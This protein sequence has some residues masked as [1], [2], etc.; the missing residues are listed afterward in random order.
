MR[1]VSTERAAYRVT[2]S[3][4]QEDIGLQQQLQ[5]QPEHLTLQH[6]V[7]LCLQQQQQRHHLQQLQHEQQQEMQH[8]LQQ[9]QQQQEHQHNINVHLQL[10]NSHG[11]HHQQHMSQL[12]HQQLQQQIQQQHLIQ[13]QQV[14]QQQQ[15]HQQH[16]LTVPSQQVV[17]VSNSSTINMIAPNNNSNH[18]NSSISMLATSSGNLNLE[19]CGLNSGSGM[20]HTTGGGMSLL[21]SEGDGTTIEVINDPG[22]Q[23]DGRVI[24]IE[25]S[26]TVLTE[27]G[28]GDSS[29]I[30][31][32]DGSISEEGVSKHLQ[33]RLTANT[34]AAVKNLLVATKDE[35]GLRGKYTR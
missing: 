29:S 9:Q 28:C 16:S 21:T 33:D 15:Q 5:L 35:R 14:Q 22:D 12:H 3:V 7:P 11:L 32:V 17:S 27:D 30:S 20:C 23:R 4:K 18:P 6:S 19:S 13:H 25:S 26:G 31:S 2:A 8:H 24:T 1:I 10:Q 34:V